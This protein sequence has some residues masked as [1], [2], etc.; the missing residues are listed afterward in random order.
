MA[1]GP[2]F[3]VG[4]M[5]ELGGGFRVRGALGGWG[6]VGGSE[7]W[8]SPTGSR[9]R[10]ASRPRRGTRRCSG[11]SAHCPS[12]CTA[13][14]GC[15]RGC[16]QGGNGEGGGGAQRGSELP[17]DPPLR[18]PPFQPLSSPAFSLANSRRLSCCS[19]KSTKTE[20]FL[21]EYRV[22]EKRLRSGKVPVKGHGPYRGPYRG[23]PAPQT[24]RGPH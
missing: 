4:A 22:V 1:E 24:A 11:R 17:S 9:C 7:L 16:L 14:T 15:R 12:G 2:G 19:G 5:F 21:M 8:G 3:G 20:H 10:A 18:P 6:G 23:A 13:H